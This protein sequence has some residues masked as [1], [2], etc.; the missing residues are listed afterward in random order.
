MVLPDNGVFGGA[1]QIVS[2]VLF[3]KR[4]DNNIFTCMSTMQG[5]DLGL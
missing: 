4:L 2:C 5:Y 1:F 3:S